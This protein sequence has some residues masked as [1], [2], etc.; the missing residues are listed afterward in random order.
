MLVI[1]VFTV[2]A[3][4]LCAETNDDLTLSPYFYIENGDPSVDHFPLK[5]TDVNVDISGVIADVHITQK[6]SNDGTRHLNIFGL[7]AH[8]Q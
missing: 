4:T 8:R 3:A 6:Y 1:G 7:C 2:S 5:E